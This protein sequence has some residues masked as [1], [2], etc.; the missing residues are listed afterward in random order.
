M[1]SP[2]MP[3]GEV[4]PEPTSTLP[5]IPPEDSLPPLPAGVSIHIT[6]QAAPKTKRPRPLPPPPLELPEPTRFE[7]FMDR[8]KASEGLGEGRTE[9]ELR[10]HRL[11]KSD[12]SERWPWTGLVIKYS[13]EDVS[14]GADPDLESMALDYARTTG[15]FG[16]YRW[17]LR[18]WE[19]GV[20]L[21]DTTKTVSLDA[22][23]DFVPPPSKPAATLPAE[24]P[25]SARDEAMSMIDLAARISGLG[26]KGPDP[27]YIESIRSAAR[28]EGY[29]A[30]ELAG[31]LKASETWRLRLEDK[32]AEAKKDGLEQGRKEGR[33]ESKDEFQA[34]ILELE[35]EQEKPASIVGE[36]VSSLGGA[37]ALQGLL[38]V[39]M[40]P[41]QPEPVPLLRPMPVRPNPQALP[42]PE[43]MRPV[44]QNPPLLPEPTRAEHH[45]AMDSIEIL[46]TLLTE[47]QE[48]VPDPHLASILTAFQT[49][50]T[51]GLQ[52]GPLGD[53]WAKWTGTVRA[54]VERITAAI[55]AQ[56]DE[57]E[58]EKMQPEQLKSLLKKRL[59]EGI[60][61][62]AIIQELET[63]ATPADLETWKKMI[64]A[65]SRS[66]VYSF[67]DIPDELQA[68]ANVLL[69][70]FIA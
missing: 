25:K 24:P 60:E 44:V 33:W 63:Q 59:V 58:G 64:R 8:L 34:K 32:V 27:A 62:D 39:I 18:G 41:K 12:G 66:L 50:K 53:W 17:T 52:E 31:Q 6:P 45:Q 4:G 22:P 37:E 48:A 23:F 11:D 10:L 51:A 43:P 19:N 2:T 57:H 1:E 54:E 61:P 15:R 3:K 47:A 9:L 69:D 35:K 7:S 38:A 16:V 13:A 40:T 49:Y 65:N 26:N 70:Q 46:L 42:P 68:R 36:I 56:M 28:K 5:A 21:V 20:L 67:L 14:N 29:D 30:G 55:E